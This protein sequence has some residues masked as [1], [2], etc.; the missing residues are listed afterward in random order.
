MEWCA[1]RSGVRERDWRALAGFAIS[2]LRH[3]A[4]VV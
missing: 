4:V 2:P 1:A 3:G